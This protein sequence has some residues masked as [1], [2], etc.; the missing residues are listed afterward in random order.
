VEHGPLL[1]A[2]QPRDRVLRPAG[3]LLV[4]LPLERLEVA[5]L[6][7]GR[8]DPLGPLLEQRHH[9]RR[10][11]CFVPATPCGCS[12]GFAAGCLRFSFT[13]R[14]CRR[15]SSSRCNDARNRFGDRSCWWVVL[16]DVRNRGR[17]SDANRRAFAPNAPRRATCPSPRP[18]RNRLRRPAENASVISAAAPSR[19][20]RRRYCGRRPAVAAVRVR[21]ENVERL[22]RV[23]DRADH[24]GRP[25][26]GQQREVLQRLPDRRRVLRQRAGRVDHELLRVDLRHVLEMELPAR[27]LLQ[28]GCGSRTS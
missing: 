18:N 1:V 13:V 12:L 27:R 10:P 7:P 2:V 3:H 5:G 14:A 4:V 11:V 16:P 8:L 19:P 25:A 21:L 15:R 20:I 26:D 22:R 23:G 9:L 28:A 24:A 6:H 17:G